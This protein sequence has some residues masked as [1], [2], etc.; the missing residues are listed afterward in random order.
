MEKRRRR[1]YRL[2]FSK[3]AVPSFPTW[4]APPSTVFFQENCSDSP[5]NTQQHVDVL[6]VADISFLCRV[7][8]NFYPEVVST[9]SPCE[10]RREKP[11]SGQ[12]L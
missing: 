2:I 6:E 5:T 10:R 9:A 1:E 12:G 4:R 8:A 3:R 11:F 7:A